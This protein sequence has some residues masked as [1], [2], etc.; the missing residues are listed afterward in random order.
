MANSGNK[1]E[2]KFEGLNAAIQNLRV[3]YRK[4]SEAEKQKD[5]FMFRD[6]YLKGNIGYINLAVIS[7][8][9]FPDDAEKKLRRAIPIGCRKI[10]FAR[11]MSM[12]IP[13]FQK[14]EL[15]TMYLSRARGVR[16]AA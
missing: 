8:A 4:C 15:S 3:H 11:M 1:S 7:M 10:E 14:K 12:D 9:I 5:F 16:K 6:E 13:E 2:G